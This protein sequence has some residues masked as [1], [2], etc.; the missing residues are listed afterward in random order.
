MWFELSATEVV[1]IILPSTINKID[2]W[3]TTT[4]YNKYSGKKEVGI[5]DVSVVPGGAGYPIYVVNRHETLLI[6]ILDLGN[7][8]HEL[9]MLLLDILLIC[10]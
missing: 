1:I 6:L 7:H 10:S 5:I 3:L 2:L 8:S 9:K 4:T